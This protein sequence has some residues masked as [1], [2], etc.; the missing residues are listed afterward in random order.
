MKRTVSYQDRLVLLNEISGDPGVEEVQGQ[1]VVSDEGG[2]EMGG[3][4][5]KMQYLHHMY[6]EPQTRQSVL[7]SLL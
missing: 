2:T 4:S 5:S 3:N 7:H 6:A 1:P